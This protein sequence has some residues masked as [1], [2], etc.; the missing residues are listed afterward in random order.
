MRLSL[1]RKSEQIYG[2]LSNTTEQSGPHQARALEFGLFSTHAV[3][4]FLFSCY[5]VKQ[6]QSSFKSSRFDDPKWNPQFK[7][8]VLLFYCL[9][10]QPIAFDKNR[11]IDNTLK[12]T[13]MFY[14]G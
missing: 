7:V 14:I 8:T 9:Q 4:Q 13:M 6:I 2:W 5:T 10:F 3:E 11:E 12:H 1:F